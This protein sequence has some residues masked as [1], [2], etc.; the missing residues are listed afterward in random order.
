VTPTPGRAISAGVLAYRWRDGEV[1]FLLVH[2]GGPFWRGKDLAAWSLPK[3]LAEAGE[4]LADAAR[5]EFEE[6]LG[7]PVTTPLAPLTPCPQPG[8]KVVCAWMTEADLDLSQFRSNLFEMEWPRGS[9]RRRSY[10]EVD[11][12]AYFSPGTA[13]SKAHRGLRPVLLEAMT[14]LGVCT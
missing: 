3:G 5:R 1:E 7:F 9:G 13:L 11:R 6:E 10:P 8:G 12:A 2:P 14:K 4:D